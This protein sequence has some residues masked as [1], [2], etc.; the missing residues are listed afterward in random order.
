MVQNTDLDPRSS[1]DQ[2]TEQVTKPKSPTSN[3]DVTMLAT[4][5]GGAAVA[6]LFFPGLGGVLVGAVIGAMIGRSAAK[7]EANGD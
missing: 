4:T 1:S 3:P 7:D 5:I 2:E 6:N